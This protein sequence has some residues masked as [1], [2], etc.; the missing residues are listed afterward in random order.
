[1][2]TCGTCGT[3]VPDN[4]SNCP[5]CGGL[6][7]EPI[8][9]ANGASPAAAPA[10]A[11]AP[12]PKKKGKASKIVVGIVILLAVLIAV[13]SCSGSCSNRADTAEEDWPTGPL[14]QMIPSMDRKCEFVN[15]TED[16]LYIQVSDG[17]EKKE[18][19]SYVDEC[20]ERGFTMDANT[21]GDVYNAY[22]P[23]GYQLSVSYSDYSKG[24][25]INLEVPKADGELIWPAVGLATTLPNPN[26]TKGSVAV[27]SATQFTAYVGEIDK[28]AYNAYVDQCMQKGFSVDY[29][30]G[31]DYFNAKD[32]QG[33]SLHLGYEGFSTMSVSLHAA[34]GNSLS[35]VSS[36]SATSEAAVSSSSNAAATSDA[37]FKQVMDDYEKFM[38]DYIAFMEKYNSSGNPVSMAA[39]YAKMMADYSTMTA[40]IDAIDEDALTDEDYLYYMEVM[41]RVSEKLANASV[42]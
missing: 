16:S 20:K 41:N 15:E 33:N 38:D 28:A 4:A 37:D 14:A 40:K 32:S 9:S 12:V 29:S 22:N 17:V 2:K 35:S 19:D 42:E 30:K 6:V 25:T 10:Q 1:M 23:E 31:D 26:K 34:K 18:F 5:T 39:D 21:I 27:D 36:S 7:G 24:V 13:G 3:E 8:A 11:A